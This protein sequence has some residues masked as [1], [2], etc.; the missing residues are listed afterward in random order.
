MSIYLLGTVVYDNNIRKLRILNDKTSELADVE[1][2]YIRKNISLEE[3][4][5]TNLNDYINVYDKEHKEFFRVCM[6]S[7]DDDTPEDE[8]IELEVILKRYAN[9]DIL[10]SNMIGELKVHKQEDIDYDN[11]INAF[12]DEK[13]G[14]LSLE[15]VVCEA[16]KHLETER[17]IEIARLYDKFIS[18]SSLMGLDIAFDYKIDGEDVIL[19][20][21]NGT[22]SS[23][24]VPNFITV[25]GE[26]SFGAYYKYNSFKTIDSIKLTNGLKRIEKMAFA[27]CK[28]DKIIIPSTV[29]TIDIL[30]FYNSSLCKNKIDQIDMNKLI[31]LGNNTIIE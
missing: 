27:F 21:Y 22:S 4:K 5:D 6:P 19:T 15:G 17:E 2:E 14:L 31:L 16:Q 20:N 9:G 3:Y 7:I 28:V 29:E 23:V 18:K 26:H 25:I 8:L 12:Y 13:Y 30:S 10:T 24:I 11:F 1:E